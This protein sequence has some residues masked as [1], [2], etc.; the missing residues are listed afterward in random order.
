MTPA[1]IVPN[2]RT[3]EL[4]THTSGEKSTNYWGMVS[5]IATEATLFGSLIFAYFYL[6]SSSPQWPPFGLH[7]PDIYHGGIG[8]AL[9]FT[10]SIPMYWADTAIRRG[11]T[12]Q[13]MIGLSITMVEASFFL[14]LELLDYA[15]S[16]FTPQ[17][18]AYGSLFFTITGLHA[19]HVFVG[20]LLMSVLMLRAWLN[21]FTAHRHLA[22]E[23]VAMYWHFVGAVW[24]VIFASFWIFPRV[25]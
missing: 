12:L 25:I 7:P 11:K 14:G 23:N 5:L 4:T 3:P 1:A 16:D 13:L 15:A 20:I 9:L 10:S 18:N 24:A 22:V 21:H 2:A 17:D 19:L 6:A 8:T